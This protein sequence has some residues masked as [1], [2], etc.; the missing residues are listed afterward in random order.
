MRLVLV[1]VFAAAGL[2]KLAHRAETRITFVE[3]GVSAGIVPSLAA[4]VPAAELAVAA[5]LLAR[6]QKRLIV[7]L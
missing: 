1:A 6:N 3:S 2:V 4:L 7:Q 5:C